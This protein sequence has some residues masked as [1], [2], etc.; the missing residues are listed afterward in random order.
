VDIY[1]AI[2]IENG[3]VAR[4]AAGERDDPLA[5][6]EAYIAEGARWVHVVDMDRVLDTGGE[7]DRL[8]RRLC[9]LSGA[10]VQ[11]GGNITDSAWACDMVDAGA[12]RVVLGSAAA[13]E[14]GRLGQL[15]SAV[16]IDRAA[17]ALDTRHEAL[18]L[19][20]REEPLPVTL[21]QLSALLRDIG[22]RTV[23]Y[24]DLARDGTLGGAELEGAAALA[25]HGFEVIAAGGVASLQELEAAARLGLDGVIVGRALLEGRFTLREA[26]ACSG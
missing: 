15:V 21:E 23:L 16:G 17:V 22:V 12:A 1:P 19:R 25:R 6:A 2:D 5:L 9:G 3:R 10:A 24:R 4:L 13:L 11:V 20:D 7:N 14:P 8:V 18:A 26:M